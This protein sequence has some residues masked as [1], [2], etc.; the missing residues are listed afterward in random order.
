MALPDLDLTQAVPMT[1]EE[2][3]ETLAAIDR[4]ILDADE[5]R[6]IP[7]EEVRQRL[8]RWNIKSSSPK[9]R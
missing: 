9:P 2:D 4:G 1:Q 8:T 6:L 5:G 7:L 3:E